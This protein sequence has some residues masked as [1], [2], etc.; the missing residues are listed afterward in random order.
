MRAQSLQ[1]ALLVCPS[2]VLE[3][4]GRGQGAHSVLGPAL[5]L[6]PEH[7]VP[8]MGVPTPNKCWAPV[9]LGVEGA[10]SLPCSSLQGGTPAPIFQMRTQ[11]RRQG[12]LSS[13]KSSTLA[14]TSWGSLGG[15]RR[16]AEASR[17]TG[18][19]GGGGRWGLVLGIRAATTYSVW[20]TRQL[21]G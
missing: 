7:C 15:R 5:L 12:G 6:G 18:G 14:T 19:W 21:G 10:A 17:V 9:P 11:A 13:S 16:L 4:R 20:G 1:P 2:L 3:G 8:P